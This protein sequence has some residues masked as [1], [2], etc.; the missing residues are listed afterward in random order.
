[1]ESEYN[2]ADL[3]YID[4]EKARKYSCVKNH[5]SVAKEAIK[6]MYR[7]VGNLKID[8]QGVAYKGLLVRLLVVPNDVST[9]FK[10]VDFLSSLGKG[11]NVNIMG[12]YFPFYL[13]KE[14]PEIALPPLGGGGG[15]GI[16]PP[17]GIEF[18]RK[19]TFTG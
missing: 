7:Q 5:P 14:F 10:E 4:E 3:K 16:R 18:N 2:L 12:Q 17:K 6:E 11:V 13:A 19:L 8:P 9:S 15:K 1:M